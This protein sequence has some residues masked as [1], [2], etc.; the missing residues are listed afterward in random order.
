MRIRGCMPVIA[1]Y[2]ILL[3]SRSAGCLVWRCLED[4]VY[5]AR[6]QT[7]DALKSCLLHFIAQRF[8]RPDVCTLSL[9]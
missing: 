5:P 4:S 9:H 2:D 1:Q 8:H 6:V 7:F 3:L